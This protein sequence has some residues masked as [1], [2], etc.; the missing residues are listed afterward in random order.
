MALTTTDN[1]DIGERHVDGFCS[2]LLNPLSGQR[3]IVVQPLPFPVPAIYRVI[4]PDG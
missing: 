3:G 4:L 2:E 1:I